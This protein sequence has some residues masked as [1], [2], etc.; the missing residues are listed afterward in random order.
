[1]GNTNLHEGHRKRMTQKVLANC[2][3]L[4][5]HELLEVLL[6]SVLPRQNTNPISHSLIR[7]FGDL[8]G[9]FNAKADELM[10]VSGVGE[11]IANHIVV[12]GQIYKRA[13]KSNKPWQQDEDWSTYEAVRDKLCDFFFGLGEE[14]LLLV[15]LS[16]K[17]K[18]ITQLVFGDRKKTSVVG[19]IPEIV[20]L[21]SIHKPSFLIVAHNHPRGDV[22]P[23][24]EDD[25]TTKKLNLLC[26]LHGVKLLDHVIVSDFKTFSYR[27][28][29]RL[30]HLKQ[31]ADIDK[32]LDEIK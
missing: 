4:S 23:S 29:G 11:K 7:A 14:Q 28:E 20:K 15:M 30:D 22:C 27:N 10:T 2:E 16:S 18:K 21:F 12:I 19:D 13:F 9:V 32:I 25:Y 26:D 31:S 1:M 5:D 8:N 3:M 17:Y 24:A 6:F